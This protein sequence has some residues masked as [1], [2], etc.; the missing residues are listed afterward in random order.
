MLQRGHPMNNAGGYQFDETNLVVILKDSPIATLGE[1]IALC[2]RLIDDPR[3]S[4][5]AGFLIDLRKMA[6][7][8][9]FDEIYQLVD[10]HKSRGFPFKG[11]YAFLVDR[12]ATIGTAN[13]F[14]SLLQ[15][16]SI[17]SE[18][19]DDES[20]ATAWLS[21]TPRA[22]GAYSRRPS[23]DDGAGDIIDERLAATR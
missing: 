8:L 5:D 18:M 6:R 20:K 10:W 23:P 16:Q 13:I 19:F 17:E 21:N 2:E 15:L 9:Q 7:L 12:P 22:S 4:E 1:T 3:V 14:C 11:R